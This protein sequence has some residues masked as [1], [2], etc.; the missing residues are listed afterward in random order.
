[1]TRR[2]KPKK[3]S[4]PIRQTRTTEI[5]DYFISN[6]TNIE[7]YTFNRNSRFEINGFCF[8]GIHDLKRSIHQ[9]VLDSQCHQLGIYTHIE[10]A[11]VI[12]A[13]EKYPCFDSFDYLHENRYYNN[14][15]VFRSVDAA[16]E[17]FQLLK[18]EYVDKL[19]KCLIHEAMDKR[20]LPMIYC[21]DGNNYFIKAN[22][23][24]NC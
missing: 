12:R 10:G 16:M 13:S 7:I 8:S 24:L 21:D 14:F 11:V 6:K 3:K 20:L 1:M 19:T 9:I 4:R 2:K 18:A 15:W 17:L 5:L 23:F 22:M